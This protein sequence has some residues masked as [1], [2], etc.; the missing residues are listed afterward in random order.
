MLDDKPLGG[1][2]KESR[3]REWGLLGAGEDTGC[4]ITFSG[5]AKLHR[6]EETGAELEEGEGESR[7][8][9][10]G[11]DLAGRGSS[12]STAGGAACLV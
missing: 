10:W 12:Q 1:K 8:D 11:E 3:V 6:A 5:Q 9:F 4:G 2:E 7:A